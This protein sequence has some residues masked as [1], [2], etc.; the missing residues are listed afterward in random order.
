MIQLHV[1]IMH[2]ASGCTLRNIRQRQ[3]FVKDEHVERSLLSRRDTIEVH[4]NHAGIQVKKAVTMHA[5]IVRPAC[6]C[7][8]CGVSHTVETANSLSQTLN[9]QHEVHDPLDGIYHGR[10]LFIL[11]RAN[12]VL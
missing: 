5:S 3:T 2:A 6:Q 9:P 12:N 10:G 8:G 4:A 11:C 7:P 1:V